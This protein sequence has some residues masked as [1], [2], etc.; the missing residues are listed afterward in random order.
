MASG[1]SMGGAWVG[2]TVGGRVVS[3]VVFPSVECS[4]VVTWAVVLCSAVVTSVGVVFSVVLTAVVVSLVVVSTVVT[5]L[6]SEHSSAIMGFYPKERKIGISNTVND[7]KNDILLNTYVFLLTSENSNKYNLICYE[8]NL[9]SPII[10]IHNL[11]NETIMS[12][13]SFF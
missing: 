8:Q 11:V 4:G 2:L 3:A 7:E 13:L 1:G 10:G 5:L 6:S 12:V 9:F